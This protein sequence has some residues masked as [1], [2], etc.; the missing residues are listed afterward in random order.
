MSSSE[1]NPMGDTVMN[2][3][4]I[5]NE[6]GI[7]YTVD[8]EGNLHSPCPV[9][10]GDDRFTTFNNNGYYNGAYCRKCIS[11]DGKV[12][13]SYSTYKLQMCLGRWHGG[14]VVSITKD[15][16]K[17]YKGN[18]TTPVKIEP[19]RDKWAES[20]S[21]LIEAGRGELTTNPGIMRYLNEERHLTKD[22]VETLNI[23]YNSEA[24][25]VDASLFGYSANIKPVVIAKGIMLPICNLSGSIKGVNIRTG[26]PEHR[27]HVIPGSKLE[28]VIFKGN[29]R[30]L[31]IVESYLDG[32]LIWQ[33]AKDLV[34]V[35]AL[36]SAYI[37]ANEELD[38]VIK[39]T[40]VTIYA[41]DTDE[42]GAKNYTYW[43]DNY[44]AIRWLVPPDFGKDPCD[45]A[46]NGLVIREWVVAVLKGFPVLYPELFSY[47]RYPTEE[48]K[49]EKLESSENGITTTP[50]ETV[51]NE[52]VKPTVSV[53]REEESDLAVGDVVEDVEFTL[54]DTEEGIGPAIKALEGF[55]TLALDTETYSE[56][57]PKNKK[58]IPALDPR[59]N[60]VRLATLTTPDNQT[61]IFDMKKL[62]KQDSI[63]ELIHSKCIVGHNLKFDFESLAVDF[64]LEVLPKTCFD[65]MIAEKLIYNATETEKAFKG[66]YKLS[67]LC[68]NY[69]GITLDKEEQSSDWSKDGLTDSQHDYA[70]KDT[71]H[72]FKLQEEQIAT[73]EEL[74]FSFEVV[75]T[76]M[77]FTPCLAK[78][79]LAGIPIDV[80]KIS[81]KL[82]QLTQEYEEAEIQWKEQHGGVNP[83][84]PKQLGKLFQDNGLYLPDTK[85]ETLA[86]YSDNP[87]VASLITLRSLQHPVKYLQKTLELE[88]SGKIYPEFEQV[89][90]PTGRMSSSGLNVQAIPS[91]IKDL[92]A[93]PPAGYSI[94][95]CDYPAIELRIAA[96]VTGEP[97]L[98][99]CFQ[100]GRDPHS[101]MAAKIKGVPVE[102]IKKDSIDRKK[103]KEANF[104]FLY[105]MGPKTFV[106][107][108]LNNGVRFTLEE[109]EL[110]KAEYLDHYQIIDEWQ[111]ETGR[112]LNESGDGTI[113]EVSLAGRV[114]VASKYCQALNYAVQG[115][116]ADMIKASVVKIDEELTTQGLKAR[117]INVVHD[118]IRVLCPNNE[119]ERVKE[120]LVKVMGSVADKLLPDFKTI[121]EP[122]VI[123]SEQR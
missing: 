11:S 82:A 53:T 88:D 100:S 93:C 98:I 81:E 99:E 116:G 71:K 43:R 3:K 106:G 18:K 51:S 73:L 85:K 6:K 59:R 12:G 28:P 91:S 87:V 120:I 74:G 37:R 60:K 14:E 36:N 13:R 101:I 55:D 110:F 31:F 69:F 8:K 57:P 34:T 117:I 79:E 97:N 78:I 2:I 90:A 94:V 61:F 96:V 4:D 39:S 49:A 102:E 9:C 10:G 54:V 109:A 122:E 16:T 7:N 47:S 35:A 108:A 32:A 77:K 104:G 41:G 75:D 22:T 56:Y 20:A 23:G 118:D 103:A 24:W 83:N 63:I 5:L 62:G 84:S 112:A 26:N 58:D 72:L 89:A 95:K 29:P 121:P 17:L 66:T 76:E 123:T 52:S 105:G 48:L 107:R 45:G 38:T 15:T 92:Y 67:T 111:K 46:N 30:C 65:T 21:M 1:L 80:I 68:S 50:L 114:V 86:K 113:K 119:V 64:G 33:E 19:D 40:P 25:S 115:T 44:G 42:A 27:Y 70:A